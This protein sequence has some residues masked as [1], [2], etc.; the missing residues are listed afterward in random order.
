MK[1]D[2]KNI[3][4]DVIF[5]YEYIKTD[6]IG[7]NLSGA[8]L[9]GADLRWYNLNRANLSGADLSG[10]DLSGVDLSGACLECANLSGAY[11]NGADLSG[12]YLKGASYGNATLEKGLLQLIGL[13]WDVFIFDK[14]IN[15]GC[16][17]FTTDE[18]E[19]FDD[20]TISRMAPGD[21]LG[22][23]NKHKQTIITLAKEHQ[24]G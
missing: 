6:L 19:Q 2:I 21:S 12:T 1:T 20:T 3:K 18:W 7:A 8:N 23:W 11:L 22:F 9:S 5:S 24:G 4:G 16:K 15:I 13:H 10:A 17:M 14:H